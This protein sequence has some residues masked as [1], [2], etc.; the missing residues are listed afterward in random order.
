MQGV[1]VNSVHDRFLY[2]VTSFFNRQST[3]V[4]RHIV[5]GIF[6]KM[7]PKEKFRLAIRLGIETC[8]LRQ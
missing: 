3:W 1:Y 7:H 5:P 8:V 6:I 2:N 4:I